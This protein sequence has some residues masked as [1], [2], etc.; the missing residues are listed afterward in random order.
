[1]LANNRAVN[2]SEQL[3]IP[4][5]L[6]SAIELIMNKALALSNKPVSLTNIE[7]K[8]LTLELAE[9]NFPISVSASNTK[10]LVTST[11]AAS[12]CTLI[13]SVTTLRQL[14]AKQQLTELIKQEQ[15]DIQ[16]DIKL[17]QQ[18]ARIA[19]ELEID[20]QTEI[21]KHIGD[22]PTHK[23]TKITEKAKSSLAQLVTSLELDVAEFLIHE[24]KLAVTNSE[25]KRFN[26]AV[27]K[28]QE[29]LSNI[30]LRLATLVNHSN[31][32]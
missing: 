16:G 32:N 10:L 8:T 2:I 20:W 5:F 7:N 9:L 21:A 25:I 19:E 22:V 27:S 4:Q 6:C 17:A 24:K 15:L 31:E 11:G 1:M 3:M 12:D 29:Q 18:F 23:L 13:S 26:Q 30:E 28:T 14:Q